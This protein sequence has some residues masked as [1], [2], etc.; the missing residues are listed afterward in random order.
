M[1]QDLDSEGLK[2]IP[3]LPALTALDF[4]ERWEIAHEL[5]TS[6]DSLLAAEAILVS[7]VRDRDAGAIQHKKA[8]TEL[9]LCLIGLGRFRGAMH[10]ISLTRPELGGFDIRDTFNYAMAEWGE[11]DILPRDLFQHVIDLDRQN[12]HSNTTNYPQCL[13]IA[14]WAVGDIEQARDKISLARQRIMTRRRPEFS[15]WRYLTVSVNQFM[16]DLDAMLEMINGEN[17]VVPMFM[18]KDIQND[19]KGGG[20]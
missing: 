4:D 10:T 7:L 17:I 13:A 2:R 11:T 19:N 6:H 3:D 20:S 1:L 16:S 5:L 18:A 9:S 12:P 14:H 15:A 8:T